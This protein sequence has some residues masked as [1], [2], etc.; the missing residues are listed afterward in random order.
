MARIYVMKINV[1][2]KEAFHFFEG[3][4]KIPLYFVMLFGWEGYDFPYVYRR[5]GGR[6]FSIYQIKILL[7]E[8][9]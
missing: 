4:M 5:L 1:H 9:K 8:I 6:T 7:L 3:S 2:A